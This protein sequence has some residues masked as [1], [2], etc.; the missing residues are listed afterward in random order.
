ML[1]QPYKSDLE[2]YHNSILFLGN[3]FRNSNVTTLSALMAFAR[4]CILMCW[5]MLFYVMYPFLFCS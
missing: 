2:L 4:L 5:F 3:L 1:Y